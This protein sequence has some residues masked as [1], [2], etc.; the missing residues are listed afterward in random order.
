METKICHKCKIFKTIDEYSKDKDKKDG[1][2]SLCKICNRQKQK[3]NRDKRAEKRRIEKEAYFNANINKILEE[4]KRKRE[5]ELKRQRKQQRLERQTLSDKYIAQVL[6]SEFARKGVKIECSE[7]DKL[8]IEAKRVTIQHFRDTG[9]KVYTKFRHSEEE[10]LQ[11]Q[12]EL[13]KIRAQ[14]IS[15]EERERRIKYLKEYYE[16]NKERLLLQQKEYLEKNKERIKEKNKRYREANKNKIRKYYQNLSEEQKQRKAES[17][18][19]YYQRNKEI[20]AIKNK[21][22]YER[23]KDSYSK[24][25]KAYKL[26][27]REKYLAYL[28]EYYQKRKS[29]TKQEPSNEKY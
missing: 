19:S 18:K 28:K 16:T 17:D 9:E 2:S 7:V 20:L 15:E 24:T 8:L 25:L 6:Q 23:N 22:R 21:E 26:K 29:L 5:E 3:V 4:K 13:A 12:K 27:H 14:N 10:R 11:R 1:L